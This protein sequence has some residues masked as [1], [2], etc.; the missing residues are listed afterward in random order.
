MGTVHQFPVKRNRLSPEEEDLIRALR[1]VV[2]AKAGPEASFAEREE[3]ALAAA[4]DA[5]KGC[6]RLDLEEIIASHEELVEV[7]GTIYRRHQPGTVK[8]YSLCGSMEF[9]RWT[10]RQ[11]GVR[12]G[13]TIV[14]LELQAGL[15]EQC[16]PA[17]GARIA[18]GYAKDH[19]R[20]CAEDMLADH[21]CAPSR[22]TLERTAKRLGSA[23]RE[24]AP[25][26]TPV[27]RAEEHVPEG[28]A[29]ISVGLDRTSVPMEEDVPE[30][31]EPSGRRRKRSKPYQRAKPERI[32]VNYRMAYVATL[33]FHDADGETLLTR[34]YAAAAHD[35]PRKQLVEPLTA[36]LRKSLTNSPSLEVGIVQDGAPELWNLLE[37]VRSQLPSVNWHEAIDRYHLSERFAKILRATEADGATRKATLSRWNDNLDKD[38]GAIDEI[39]GWVESLFMDGLN[40]DDWDLVDALDDHLTYLDNNKDRMRY[41]EQL[42]LGLPVGS[43]ITEAA[44]K[45]VIKKR[46]NDSGQ[47]WRP[48]GLDAVLTL[49]SLQMSERLPRF[50]KHLMARH[51]KPV[52][53]AVA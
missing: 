5:T 50:W 24:L 1:R 7:E 3:L 44:C 37:P 35:D 11:C 8:Y 26:V 40:R 51:R 2:D 34:R 41:T 52:L 6:L 13:P 18:L 9:E 28:A 42:R 46:T 10:Y 25:S 36:D 16:T 31:E 48:K 29:S 20:S 14:P 19:M 49:R 17:L 4:N 21:R 47:R 22:S 27:L 45:S 12:N 30:G 38:D 33:S 43:G 15:V 32:D 23:A 53:P 39:H